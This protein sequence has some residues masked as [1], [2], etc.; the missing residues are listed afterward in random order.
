MLFVTNLAPSA[1]A[2]PA[3]SMSIEPIGT[4][5]VS[6]AWRTSPYIAA[7]REASRSKATNGDRTLRTAVISR[8]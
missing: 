2:W 6:R 1:I 8:S 5:C 7:D 3:M 4:P